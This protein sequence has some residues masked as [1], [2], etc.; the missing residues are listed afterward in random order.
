MRGD[1]SWAEMGKT[2]LANES[3]H[4]VY[5]K[6][7]TVE[8]RLEERRELR[9]EVYRL[10]DQIDQSDLSAQG[11]HIALVMQLND[12]HLRAWCG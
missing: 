10:R 4:P 5:S 12:K 7:F 9:F 8:F 1:E 6:S 3:R 11:A 2:E